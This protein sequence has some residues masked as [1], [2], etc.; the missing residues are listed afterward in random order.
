M[1]N[2]FAIIFVF[3]FLVVACDDDDS[4]MI[5]IP[6]IDTDISVPGEDLS[7]EWLP[8]MPYV[9]YPGMPE[10]DPEVE[11]NV[12]VIDA[13]AHGKKIMSVLHNESW[14][15][16]L[17]SEDKENLKQVCFP[18][19][20]NIKLHITGSY[21]EYNPNFVPCDIVSAS[22]SVF[23]LGSARNNLA[24]YED[25][26]SFPNFPLV[27]SSAGNGVNT[28]TQY[29]WDKCLEWGGLSWN[30]QVLPN[31]GWNP[32]GPFTPEQM[33]M[34]KPGDV[35][36][37]Y[38]VQDLDL[39]GHK[40]DW[41]VVGSKLGFGNKPGPVL[42]DRWICT[43]YSFDYHD[44]KTDGT[45]YST[46]FVVKIAAEIKRRAPLYTN[47]EIAQLIFSTADDF[48]AEGCDD[49]YGHGCMNPAKIWE[50]LTKRGY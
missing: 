1:K 46:P 28:F 24:K 27:I 34:Y 3:A 25:E 32:D 17:T 26:D 6:E 8:G 22:F 18:T 49:I 44:S 14:P 16:T 45:S 48:G 47:D 40:T 21:D 38:V 23:G 9:A 4:I 43:Y 50:E 30:D 5:E 36:S 10:N 31:T 42:K 41:I 33:A 39:K 7:G 11:V 13:E 20:P 37:A 35:G 2:I 12:L 29:A 15:W 19:H